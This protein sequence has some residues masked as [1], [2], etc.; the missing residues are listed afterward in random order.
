ML[1]VSEKTRLL[2]ELKSRFNIVSAPGVGFQAGTNTEGAL[3]NVL[4]N[5]KSVTRG[6]LENLKKH[7]GADYLTDVQNSKYAEQFQPG[8]S[9]P[10]GSRRV[11][12][13]GVLGAAVGKILGSPTIGS[14]VGA[15]A[16]LYLDREGGALAG[17]I[18]DSF[19]AMRP[20][21]LQANPEMMRFGSLLDQAVRS[22]VP[23]EVANEEL[24]KTEPAYRDWIRSLSP[25]RLFDQPALKQG[26]ERVM[27]L[28]PP[29]IP[30]EGTPVYTVPARRIENPLDRKTKKVA[31][32]IMPR[33]VDVGAVRG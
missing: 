31:K 15:G 12:A 6:T 29:P 19:R 16:G 25:K 9:R 1:P 2:Q 10:N 32:V 33:R 5:N 18:I 17:K 3:A 4:N 8:G 24:K 7:V 26:F 14:A 22:G 23:I 30:K 13:G 11:A 27:G 21:Q 20:S 28:G